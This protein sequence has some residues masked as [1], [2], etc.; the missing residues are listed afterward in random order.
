M[1]YTI[2]I[3]GYNQSRFGGIQEV[4]LKDDGTL[5]GLTGINGVMNPSFLAWH[6]PSRRIFSVSE[7]PEGAELCVLPYAGAGTAVR[8]RAPFEGK[9]L[10]HI[11]VNPAATLVGGACYGSGDVTL[12]ACSET[13]FVREVFHKNYSRD[14]AISHPH[15]MC[16]SP[17]GRYFYLVDLGRDSVDCFDCTGPTP[18]EHGR[19]P[20]LEG[21]GPRQLLFHPA[22]PVAYLV[23]EYSNAVYALRYDAASGALEV[24]QRL[25]TLPD[26]FTDIS[27]GSSLAYNAA[28]RVL[29]ATNRGMESIALY[30]VAD[31]GAL[32]AFGI[33]SCFGSW[34]RHIA[35]TH[36]DAF[37]LCCNERTN[38]L[39]VLPLDD[40]GVP[41]SP[42]ARIRH[43]SCSFAVDIG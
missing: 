12:Y 38:E 17:D 15:C 34:P 36:D 2:L 20:L 28:A 27:Y 29:Y 41:G 31:D 7:A 35:L 26:T 39:C 32:S 9:G 40:Q 42:V 4:V 24:T 25:S 21:D 13:G 43:K 1:S 23:T 6:A 37:L 14:G 22:F 8:G 33:V 5:E 10:C 18:A 30:R 16:P 3:G 19:L 11:G